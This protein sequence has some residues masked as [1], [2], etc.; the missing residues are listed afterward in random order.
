MLFSSTFRLTS[1]SSISPAKAVTTPCATPPN[2]EP[3]LKWTPVKPEGGWTAANG[4]VTA[5]CG[6]DETLTKDGVKDTGGEAATCEDA[7]G[8]WDNGN[9]GGL[10]LKCGRWG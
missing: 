8:T 10:D 9:L 2:I 3:S 7:G 4:P 6:Q 5:V 1:N